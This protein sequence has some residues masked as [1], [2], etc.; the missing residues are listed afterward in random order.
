MSFVLGPAL[1][2][3]ASVLAHPAEDQ[4]GRTHSL[5]GL[6]AVVTELGIAYAPRLITVLGPT[7]RA[8]PPVRLAEA[9][10]VATS[11]L[12]GGQTLPVAVTG[13]LTG[14]H[15]PIVAVAVASTAAALTMAIALTARPT[16]H[17]AEAGHAAH[18]R[19]DDVPAR[20]RS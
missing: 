18:T 20:T 11:A 19:V 1:V 15:G 7:E 10:A 9:M 4:A 8:V 16:T 12:V 6:Y 3:L 17:A 2:A 14:I 13:S 5:P